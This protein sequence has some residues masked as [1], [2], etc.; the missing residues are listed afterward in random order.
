M[1]SVWINL[2]CPA[3]EMEFARFFQEEGCMILFFRV[4]IGIGRIIQNVAMHR[5]ALERF[6]DPSYR[7]GRDLLLISVNFPES[8][9]AQ[10]S[11]ADFM[12]VNS[13]R[14]YHL[15]AY[16]HPFKIPHFFNPSIAIVSP[17]D[18]PDEIALRWGGVKKN[19]LKEAICG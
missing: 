8:L 17:A 16:E 10:K 4:T 1:N 14:E 13:Q 11:L 15:T 7:G 18:T 3:R 5:M 2:S 6:A 9:L 19:L 12:E